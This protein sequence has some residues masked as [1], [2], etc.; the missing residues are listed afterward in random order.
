MPFEALCICTILK[1]IVEVQLS[2]LELSIQKSG[3]SKLHVMAVFLIH[4]HFATCIK[5]VVN[6]NQACSSQLRLD[7]II[8]L[9]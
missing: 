5:A 9:H 3:Y 4:K 8:E 7:I 1:K 6:L 2:H